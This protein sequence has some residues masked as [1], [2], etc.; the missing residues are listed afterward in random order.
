LPARH[1]NR[2]AADN[3]TIRRKKYPGLEARLGGVV[4]AVGADGVDGVR[5]D[6]HLRIIV[7]AGQEPKP[8]LDCPLLQMQ[9]T[10]TSGTKEEEARI[11]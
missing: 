1:G 10:R 9:S 3:I 4:A 5:I 6:P 8:H 7:A 2:R 11:R